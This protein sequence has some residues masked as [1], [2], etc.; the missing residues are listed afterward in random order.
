MPP[1]TMKMAKLQKST[2]DD[3]K[4]SGRCGR[5]KCCLRYEQDV[6][7]EHQA[8]LPAI[9]SRIVTR[10]GQGVVRAHEVLARKL[11]VQFE[12]GRREPIS[13]DDVLTKL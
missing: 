11:L 12:D 3:N 7:E 5:L 10:A 1:V 6:Y 4:I 8:E 2:L 13:V 9:G